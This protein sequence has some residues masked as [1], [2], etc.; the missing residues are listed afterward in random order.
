MTLS[1]IWHCGRWGL[2]C[3]LIGAS[4]CM[5]YDAVPLYRGQFKSPSGYPL[6][7][8]DVQNSPICSASCLSLSSNR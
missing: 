3:K 7:A 8:I 6:R 4:S 1:H 5:I 2:G